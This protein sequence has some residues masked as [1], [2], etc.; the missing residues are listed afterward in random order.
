MLVGGNVIWPVVAV[1][2]DAHV[3][4]DAIMV[5]AQNLIHTV[6]VG[7]LTQPAVGEPKE[8]V[9]MAMEIELFPLVGIYMLV[10]IVEVFAVERLTYLELVARG[11]QVDE[12]PIGDGDRHHN[13]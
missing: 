8:L 5:V 12:Q 9:G 10:G 1:G 4:R 6:D 13:G 7:F 11:Y 3:I 2:I